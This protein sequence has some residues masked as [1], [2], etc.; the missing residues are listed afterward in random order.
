MDGHIGVPSG[1]G[2]DRSIDFLLRVF[3]H[4]QWVKGRGYSSAGHDLYLCGTHAQLFPRAQQY[5]VNAIGNNGLPGSFDITQRTCIVFRNICGT[6]K[7]TMT[8]GLRNGSATGENARPLHVSLINGSFQAEGCAAEITHCSETPEQLLFC[9][10]CRNNIH[11]ADITGKTHRHLDGF[12]HGMYMRVNQPGHQEF[13]HAVYD[14]D[15]R[16]LIGGDGGGGNLCDD[17][18]CDQHMAIHRFV[19]LTVEDFHVGEEYCL[20][21]KSGDR[22]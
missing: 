1:S 19:V 9:R 10:L 6:A 14:S 11:I 17:I 13:S 4:I 12:K 21:R 8:A 18:I 20:L 3:S 5:L 7:I 15:H 22:Q 2:F 16:T